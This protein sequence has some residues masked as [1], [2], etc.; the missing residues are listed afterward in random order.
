MVEIHNNVDFNTV[1]PIDILPSSL[2][3]FTA[4]YSHL[5][6]LD[7]TCNYPYYLLTDR[8]NKDVLYYPLFVDSTTVYYI[9]LVRVDTHISCTTVEFLDAVI[10]CDSMSIE[11]K[12]KVETALRYYCDRTGGT[13]VTNTVANSHNSSINETIENKVLFEFQLADE[14]SWR[15]C[16]LA[17]NEVDDKLTVLATKSNLAGIKLSIDKTTGLSMSC[18]VSRGSDKYLCR[19]WISYFYNNIPVITI[20]CECI[21]TLDSD[22]K[23]WYSD[24]DLYDYAKWQKASQ[25]FYY[26]D[27]KFSKNDIY[28]MDTLFKKSDL[29]KSVF[30]SDDYKIEKFL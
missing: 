30:E 11:V 19:F 25:I 24:K 5:K 16:T 4:L 8:N 29:F 17:I 13:I 12:N 9:E 15:D 23:D 27:F 1:V 18:I 10:N 2:H 3:G 7:F 22:R 21:T 6:G 28:Y 20:S 26:K 14:S